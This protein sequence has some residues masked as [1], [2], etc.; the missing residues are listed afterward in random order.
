MSDNMMSRRGYRRAK[1]ELRAHL[2]N[3]NRD[4]GLSRRP[5]HERDEQ[6]GRIVARIIIVVIVVVFWIVAMRNG[7]CAYSWWL[8]DYCP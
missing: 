8:V 3:P 7:E 5:Y 4:R 1:R 6:I 2:A